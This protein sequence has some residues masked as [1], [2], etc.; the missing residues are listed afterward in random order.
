MLLARIY[1]KPKQKANLY[2]PIFSIVAAS[3]VLDSKSQYL[4]FSVVF[5]LGIRPIALLLSYKSC[6]T[7][8]KKQTD[9]HCNI[10]SLDCGLIKQLNLF[11]INKF[12]MYFTSPLNL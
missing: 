2:L 10:V 3:I 7:T 11:S 4:M 1:L 6:D 9:S 8:N 5:F 12:N